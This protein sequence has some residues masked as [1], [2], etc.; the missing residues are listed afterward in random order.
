MTGFKAAQAI[1]QEGCCIHSC[2]Q[3]AQTASSD[4]ARNFAR[5]LWQQDTCLLITTKRMYTSLTK[6]YY[7]FTYFT[8]NIIGS[9]TY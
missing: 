8:Q 6:C 1:E 5:I 4:G 9:H 3:Q 2:N 7:C